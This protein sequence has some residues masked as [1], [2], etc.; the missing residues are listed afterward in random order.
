LT[1]AAT[2]FLMA[3]AALILSPLAAGIA[4]VLL[5]AVFSIAS[6]VGSVAFSDVMG[7]TV[8]KGRRGRLL[9]VRATS[10]GGLALIAGFFLRQ[11][12]GAESDV[13][14]YLI[15]LGTA[16]L[17]WFLAALL[18]AAI[19]EEP[20]ATEGGRNALKEAQAGWQL[21]QEQPG[22]RHFI[23]ARAFLLTVELAI[24]FYA[25]YARRLIQEDVGNLGIFVMAASLA[26]VLSSPLWGR[27]ADRSSRTVMAW[28]GG[29]AVLTGVY[30]LLFGALPAELQTALV[31]APVFLLIG[32]ARAGV[33][34][35][36]KTYLV[37]GAPQKEMPLYVALSN[38]LIGAL[39]LLGSGLG[40]IAELLGLPPLIVLLALLSGTGALISWRLPEATEMVGSEA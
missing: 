15:L 29:M 7:K 23:V 31:Y 34:L 40:L 1:E 6:G 24:P 19:E 12:V 27:F 21:L 28:G 4:V 32:F 25:L 35:G 18:F 10:G 8:P 3:V 30:A 20:G 39:T 38:S 16:A 13:T 9:A 33:R 14:P 5:L 36:R 26:A 37:D 22:F 17:L 11:Y 2:L